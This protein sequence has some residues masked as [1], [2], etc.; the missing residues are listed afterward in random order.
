MG[1]K[2]AL[3]PSSATVWAVPPGV[4]RTLLQYP[5][6]PLPEM[7]GFH[8]IVVPQWVRVLSEVWFLLVY[9]SLT[10]RSLAV[11]QEECEMNA[12]ILLLSDHFW[13]KYSN[14]TGE[15]GA[16]EKP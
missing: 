9:W 7:N 10:P 2:L 3:M 16:Q 12:N 13:E 15:G 14:H 1:E 11:V 8:I 6:S 4:V 5:R